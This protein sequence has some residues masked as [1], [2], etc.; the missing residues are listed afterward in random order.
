MFFIEY[1]YKLNDSQ[2]RPLHSLRDAL[3]TYFFFINIVFASCEETFTTHS[4]NYA[5]Y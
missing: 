2:Y 1:I 4:P 5:T 3:E